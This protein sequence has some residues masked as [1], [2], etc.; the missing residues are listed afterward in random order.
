MGEVIILLGSNIHPQLN[1][2]EGARLLAGRLSFLRSSSVWKT[3]AVGSSGPD[4]YNAAVLCSTTLHA[5]NLKYEVLRPIEKQ[6]GRVRS[7]DK[8]AD[9]T[10]DLDIVIFNNKVLEPQ[11]WVTD[12]IILPV[13]QIF[14][15]LL[16]PGTNKSILELAE[17]IKEKSAALLL[18][19]FELITKLD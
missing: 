19:D 8:F 17:E 2:R 11:L 14:P 18:T 7:A 16:Q 4:F 3:S 13:A 5:K 1:I 10:I 9:R 15:N 12:F 6:L